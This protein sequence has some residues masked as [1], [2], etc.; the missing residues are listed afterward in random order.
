LSGCADLNPDF[1]TEELC[2][3]D[4]LPRMFRVYA[5]S[6]MGELYRQEV[7]RIRDED[8]KGKMD[9]EA[10]TGIKGYRENRD[11]VKKMTTLLGSKTMEWPGSY[12]IDLKEL[13]VAERNTPAQKIVFLFSTHS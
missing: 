8:V 6:E 3:A 2:Q 4:F 7:C 12:Q 10:M 9:G 5:K 11:T 1:N 13:S